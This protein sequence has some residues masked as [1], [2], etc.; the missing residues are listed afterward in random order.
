MPITLFDNVSDCCGC[1]ACA[2]VCQKSAIKMTEGASGFLYPEIDS[3]AC[4]E[5]GLCRR[6]CAFQNGV[7]LNKPICAWAATA[8][9]E[10]IL[11][12]SSSGGMP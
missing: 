9:S 5:C 8:V 10:D 2:D 6:V 3:E 11:K 12:S 7:E 4:V 1:G